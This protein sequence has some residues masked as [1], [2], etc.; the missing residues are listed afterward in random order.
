M[1]EIDQETVERLKKSTEIVGYLGE[2]VKDQDG[3]ILSGRHRK[4][5]D[6]EWPEKQVNVTDPLQR[7]LLILHYNVQ[8]TVP[9]EETQR[10]L[11]RIAKL[12]EST[13]VAKNEVCSEVAKLVPYSHQYVTQL[14]PDDYKQ[15][16]KAVSP[17]RPPSVK[18]VKQREQ[19]PKLVSVESEDTRKGIQ[20]VPCQAEGCKI[21]TRYAPE[22][23]VNGKLLCSSCYRKTTGQDPPK[24]PPRIIEPPKKAS[25]KP[26]EKVQKKVTEPPPKEPWPDRMHPRISNMHQAIIER[27]QK[28]GIRFQTEKE[29][30]VLSTT[31]DIDLPNLFIYL[32]GE[33]VHEGREERD[34]ELRELLAKRYHK[35]ILTLTYTSNTNEQQDMIFNKI[36]KEISLDI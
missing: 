36:M 17:G 26:Q 18:L 19:Y 15:S 16:D 23:V 8:R 1:S 7:E 14:L 29:Y 34:Q 35:R 10:R 3:A 5:A 13:G 12:V 28:E 11:L 6:P 22:R 9:R 25:E 33:E 31:P 30:C 24:L 20:W 27:L 4:A 32:D 2:V 21:K